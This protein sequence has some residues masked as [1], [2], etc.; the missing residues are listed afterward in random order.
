MAKTA[1]KTSKSNTAKNRKNTTSKGRKRAKAVADNQLR[2]DC[3]ILISMA[4]A[5]ILVLSNFNLAGTLG[6]G[7]KWLMFGLFGV[8]EYIFPLILVASII[9][10]MVNRDLIRVARIKTV[11]AYCLVWV[12]CG[13][14]QC[15]Y[16]K[17]DI[18]EN[19][20][21]SIFEDCADNKT[22]GGFLGGVLCKMLSPVGVIRT[23][24]ILIILAIICIV[25]ITEKSFL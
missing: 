2:N 10:L 7:I 19:G 24:L 22:G 9:F 14:I 15:V 4:C 11:A 17:P 20:I 1:S 3:I 6:R 13:M 18:G 16:N 21:G 23:A 8:M 12:L 25:V 5:I